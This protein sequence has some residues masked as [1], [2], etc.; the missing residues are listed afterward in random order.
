MPAPLSPLESTADEAIRC[1][2]GVRAKN[3]FGHRGFVR[4]GRMFAF[5]AEDGLAFK[6]QRRTAEALYAAGLA[7]PFAY[8]GG[9]QMRGW[10]IVPLANAEQLA[11]ALTAAHDA[12]EG[13]G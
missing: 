6:A 1:W 4:D 5:F 11:D 8:G 2:P 13:V 7:T 10:P 9:M 12:Y 3:V